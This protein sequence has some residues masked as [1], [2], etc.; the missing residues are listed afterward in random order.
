MSGKITILK[1]D[2]GFVMYEQQLLICKTF[3][4]NDISTLLDEL[5]KRLK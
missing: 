5:K 3:V 2:N 1:M 4:T